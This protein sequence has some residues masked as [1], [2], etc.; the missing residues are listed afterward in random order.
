MYGVVLW[1]DIEGSRAVIW[2]EDHGDLA[3]L[4][5]EEGMHS[6][7]DLDAGDLIH[8]DVMWDGA[9]RRANNAKLVASHA[10]PTLPKDL[11]ACSAAL[12]QPEGQAEAC[13]GP[14]AEACDG[15]NVVSFPATRQAELPRHEVAP[16]VEAGRKAV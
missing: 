12:L 14:N 2:C 15:P 1:K 8:F 5:A 9:L 10:F 6:G 4:S 7:A 3:F 16:P 11:A 13:D